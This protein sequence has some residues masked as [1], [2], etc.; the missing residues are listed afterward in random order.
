MIIYIQNDLRISE[1][2]FTAVYNKLDDEYT[3]TCPDNNKT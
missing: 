2:Y 3:T 1:L